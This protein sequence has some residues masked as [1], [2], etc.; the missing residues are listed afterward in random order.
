M[1]EHK[2]IAV[3]R[4]PGCGHS[5]EKEIPQSTEVITIENAGDVAPRHR[6]PGAEAV[7]V[8]SL[9]KKDGGYVLAGT[10][11]PSLCPM[12]GQAVSFLATEVPVE[13]ERLSCECGGKVFAVAVK[14]IQMEKKKTDPNWQF[15]LDVNCQACKK[16]RFREKI[17][18]FFRLKKI[19]VGLTGIDIQLK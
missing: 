9:K 13:L 1:S 17:V 3:Q 2:E 12:C 4:C 15:E 14:S 10:I 19:K 6:G 5:F 16:T 11:S 8:S 18:S 7:Q